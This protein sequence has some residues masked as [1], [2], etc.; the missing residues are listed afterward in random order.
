VVM[1]RVE[2]PGLPLGYRSLVRSG[3][4]LGQEID[5]VKSM[6]V[7][8]GSDMATRHRSYPLMR[9]SAERGSKNLIAEKIELGVC[10]FGAGVGEAVKP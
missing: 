10:R 5:A 2:T 3:E 6:Q 4:A 1:A 8:C 7:S 9:H